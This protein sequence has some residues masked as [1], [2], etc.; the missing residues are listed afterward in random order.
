MNN[1]PDGYISLKIPKLS[2]DVKATDLDFVMTEIK[3]I[4]DENTLIRGKFYT[5]NGQDKGGCGGLGIYPP[6]TLKKKVLTTD[7]K[8]VRGVFTYFL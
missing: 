5:G 4:L 6:I 1:L 3:Q 8:D 2:V 7:W